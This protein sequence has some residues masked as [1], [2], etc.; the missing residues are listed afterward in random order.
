M[1]HWVWLG[2]RD[3]GQLEVYDAEGM[4]MVSEYTTDWGELGEKNLVLDNGL[5]RQRKAL[6]VT[7]NPGFLYMF[8]DVAF[9]LFILIS[10]IW[11]MDSGS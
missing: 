1:S 11:N 7:S 6:E 9:F 3:F 5:T 8:W 2:A 10:V 4:F